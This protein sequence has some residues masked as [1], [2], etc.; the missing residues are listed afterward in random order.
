V[1]DQ[2]NPYPVGSGPV[3]MVEDPT[4][5]YVYTSNNVDGT[6]TGKNLDN[7]TGDLQNLRRGAVFT[8][9]GLPTCLAISGNVN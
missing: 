1:P 7:N 5:Q 4:S 6:V 8:A 9:T 2:N 3:C